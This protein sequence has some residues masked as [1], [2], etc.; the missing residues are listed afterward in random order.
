MKS[1]K[2]EH[3]ATA[4]FAF[5]FIILSQLQGSKV[6]SVGARYNPITLQNEEVISTRPLVNPWLIRVFGLGAIASGAFCFRDDLLE[7]G[8]DVFEYAKAN[9][10]VQGL[11]DKLPAQKAT[12]PAPQRIDPSELDFP[13]IPLEFEKEEYSIPK[14]KVQPKKKPTLEESFAEVMS[15]RLRA[16]ASHKETVEGYNVARHFF[17]FDTARNIPRNLTG[18]LAQEQKDLDAT[19]PELKGRLRTANGGFSF[20][21]NKTDEER[22]YPTE[23][24]AN[25]NQSARL[26]FL[27][28]YENFTKKPVFADLGHTPHISVAGTTNSGKDS[29]QQQM[30]AS[31]MKGYSPEELKFVIA[32]GKKGLNYQHMV[33]S[34]YL[35]GQNPIFTTQGELKG[36]LHELDI[37]SETRMADFLEA[38]AED[39]WGYKAKGNEMS[40]VVVF[41]CE[42]S[43]LFKDNPS[44]SD[45][46][47]V[48]T[49]THRSQGIFYVFSTQI[50]NKWS[51]PT[52]IRNN[53]AMRMLFKTEN[54]ELSTFVFNEEQPSSSLAGKGHGIFYGGDGYI[55]IQSAKP[56]EE[57][58]F[59]LAHPT[60]EVKAPSNV[61]LFQRKTS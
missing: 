60:E 56:S 11:F 52:D 49:K 61:I 25:E 57:E 41:I 32:D 19:F 24:L 29:W 8:A 23:I 26:S 14:T 18:L 34:P 5:G 1:I 37:L 21:V 15:Q 3:A 6:D 27:I 47:I 13:T 16:K 48:K 9:K 46:L 58:L 45:D 42:T 12:P 2:T 30:Q 54:D 17:K 38:G 55:E 40:C 39:I 44:I 28:G 31:L 36:I 20:T 50:P 35:F 7:A 43:I 59:N 10:K 33:D 4:F 22:Q 53:S 51:L